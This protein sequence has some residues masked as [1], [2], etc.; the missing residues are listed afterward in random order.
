MTSIRYKNHQHL[1]KQIG[2]QGHFIY[3]AMV[4]EELCAKD[5]IVYIPY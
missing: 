4:A 1:W 3:F 2:I 5:F